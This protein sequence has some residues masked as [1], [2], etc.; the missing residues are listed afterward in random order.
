M[1]KLSEIKARCEAAT[2]GPWKDGERHEFKVEMYTDQFGS[3]H[4]VATFHGCML[5]PIEYKNMSANANFVV[6]ARADLPA[7]VDWAER[8]ALFLENYFK[9]S[10]RVEPLSEEEIRANIQMATNEGLELLREIGGND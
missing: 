6:N 10:V 2:P 7:L 1:I 4:R 5:G 3:H 9:G 8:A